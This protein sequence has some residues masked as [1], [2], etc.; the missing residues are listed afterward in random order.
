[1]CVLWDANEKLLLKNLIF[2]P[3]AKIGDYKIMIIFISSGKMGIKIY[4]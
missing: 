2:Y 1:M 4:G 3:Q